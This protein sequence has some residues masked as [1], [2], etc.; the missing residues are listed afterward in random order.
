MCGY[1]CTRTRA[2]THTHTHTDCGAQGLKGIGCRQKV[3]GA[4]ENPTHLSIPSAWG[5]WGRILDMLGRGQGPA[6]KAEFGGVCWG[7][8]DSAV[9]TET[10]WFLRAIQS[11]VIYFHVVHTHTRTHT[12][13]HTH[14]VSKF[15]QS[16]FKK[17]F[18][19]GGGAGVRVCGMDTVLE[20]QLLLLDFFFKDISFW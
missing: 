19:W 11:Y 8:G 16:I 13:T 3:E 7:W 15:A 12:H 18:P 2:H 17:Y 20:G 6:T 10:K 9:Y 14:R 4:T 5:S 1:I